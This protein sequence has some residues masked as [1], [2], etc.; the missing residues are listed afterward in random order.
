[1]WAF[2]FGAG[3]GAC[4]ILALM[5]MGLRS[6]TPAQAAALSGMAQCL[7]YLLAATG[8]MAAGEAH[9]WAGNWDL[10]LGAGMGL[11]LLMAAFGMLAGRARVIGQSVVLGA[12]A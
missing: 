4:L 8:P 7:G 9:A 11:A 10:P 1:M 2:C 5:F 6:S 12:R 3:S